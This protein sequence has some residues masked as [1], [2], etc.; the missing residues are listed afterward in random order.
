[1]RNYRT[2]AAA[3]LA[4]AA[5]SC[6][7]KATVNCSVE[8]LPEGSSIVVKQLDINSYKT[9]DTLKAGRGGV[10]TYKAPVAK[11][12]PEF[13]YFFYSDRQIAALL[14]EEG[15]H[16]KVEADTLG[17][18]SVE[19][20]E[21]STLLAEANS[22]YARFISDMAA[23]QDNAAASKAYVGH[24][25]EAIK[26]VLEN[27]RSLACVPV[28][29]ENVN[30]L[31]VFS[32]LTDAI[33]FRNVC[34]SLKTVYPESR[35]VKALDKEASR[36]E[37]QLKLQNSLAG[38]ETVGY[39]DLEMPDVNGSKVKLSSVDSKVTLLHFW[40]ADDAAQKM[41]AIESLKP[42]YEEL[43]PRGLEIYSVCLTVDKA[44]WASVVKA[45]EL[46]W[47]NVNDGLGAASP[48]V[49]LYNL[50]ALPTT[51]ILADGNLNTASV[52]GVDGLRAEIARLLK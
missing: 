30:N 22:S 21:G 35:F 5:V 16:A 40:D 36:R 31:P 26:F 1:M 48:S 20:S 17:N 47:V 27:S 38:A 51:F 7:P 2:F 6:G 8:G 33:F 43:H 9:A 42:L 52:T 41:I 50:Q 13:F 19:G 44:L 34:D 12:Q 3:L 15:E 18:Y 28:L 39:P 14:L 25:R 45:Q 24:Y 10:F 46:T 4:L 29:Y 37:Q 23:A 49:S 11:G 32:Q